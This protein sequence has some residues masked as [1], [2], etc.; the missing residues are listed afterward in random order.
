MVQEELLDN[1]GKMRFKVKVMK[2]SARS[3]VS[4]TGSAPS[5]A[6]CPPFDTELFEF[7]STIREYLLERE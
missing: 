6:V 2:G 3:Y 1:L 5:Y 4:H 7:V